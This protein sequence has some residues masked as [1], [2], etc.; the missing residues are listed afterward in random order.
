MAQLRRHNPVLERRL[1]QCFDE[2]DAE[3]LRALLPTL[4]V[5]EFR[6]ASF[7]LAN[8]L[9]PSVPAN[10]FWRFFA[11]VVPSDSKAFLGTFLKV[12]AQRI[13]VGTLQQD[14]HTLS[15]FMLTA[16]PIDKRKTLQ[17]LLPVEK[18]PENISHLLVTAS[19]QTIE[20][21][22]AALVPTD[23]VACYYCLFRAMKLFDASTAQIRSICLQLMRLQN[24]LAYRFVAVIKVYFG[25]ENLPGT[26]SLK[27]A[28]W[29]LGRLDSSY[30]NFR[31]I[32]IPF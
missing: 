21:Y 30:E 4:T 16:T 19:P 26:L 11:V 12:A 6:T 20:A 5:A 10:D 18:H 9:L 8:S 17:A 27:I 22:A 7:M 2:R 29:Q 28:P 25:I 23:N 31:K 24:P 15:A 14:F 13:A 32:V 3:A 1:M